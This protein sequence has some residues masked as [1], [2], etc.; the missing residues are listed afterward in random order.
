MIKKALLTATILALVTTATAS[1]LQVDEIQINEPI[2]GGETVEEQVT[3]SWNGDTDTVAYL[4]SQVE[5]E[6]TSVEGFNVSYG[7]NPLVVPENGQTTT[8]MIIEADYYLKPDNF[9][10]ITEAST[11]VDKEVQY[12]DSGGGTDYVYTTTEEG[13]LN[14]SKEEELREKV[15]ETVDQNL[16][17]QKELEALRERLQEVNSTDDSDRP[18][19]NQTQGNQTQ[20]ETTQ[21]DPDNEEQETSLVGLIVELILGWLS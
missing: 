2:H 11:E 7:N 19:V 5:A 1:E 9:T 8:E 14:K 4:Q 18:A 6:N 17:L 10:I 12:R 13:D 15:N 16:K 21:L 3:V 20:N